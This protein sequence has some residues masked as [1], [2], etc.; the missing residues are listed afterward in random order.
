MQPAA[1]L[2]KHTTRV[3]SRHWIHS[4]PSLF[5]SR[6]DSSCHANLHSRKGLDSVLLLCFAWTNQHPSRAFKVQP[7]VP[8]SAMVHHEKKLSLLLLPLKR[9]LHQGFRSCFFPFSLYTVLAISPFPFL[10]LGTVSQNHFSLSPLGCQTVFTT[11][12]LCPSLHI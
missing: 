11:H 10:L 2:F 5:P 12:V 7:R 8:A 1:Q 3:L 9:V 6:V 4:N